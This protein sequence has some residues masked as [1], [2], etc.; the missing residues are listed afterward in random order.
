MDGRKR[1]G[2]NLKDFRLNFHDRFEPE[3]LREA[4]P[5]RFVCAYI[6]GCLKIKHG[7]QF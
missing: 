2:L 6:N 7:A 1:L 4:G 3:L 5:V